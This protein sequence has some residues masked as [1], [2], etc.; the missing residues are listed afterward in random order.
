[1]AD[2]EF[3][4]LGFSYLFDKGEYSKSLNM[5]SEYHS[6]LKNRGGLLKIPGFNNKQEEIDF[7]LN[8]QNPKTGAFIDESVPYCVYWEISQNIINHMEALLDSRSALCNLN[9]H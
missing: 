8:L 7:F 3:R 2:F 4:M 1:M 5:L 6:K 9:I